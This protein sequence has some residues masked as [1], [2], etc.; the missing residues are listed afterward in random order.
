MAGVRSVSSSSDA[1]AARRAEEAKKAEEARKAQEAKR[2]EAAKKAE[3]AKKAQETQ[4]ARQQ[5]QADKVALK[6]EDNDIKKK[7]D[8]KAF[9]SLISNISKFASEDGEGP[10]AGKALGPVKPDGN[11][12]VDEDLSKLREFTKIYSAPPD[13]AG[14]SEKKTEAGAEQKAAKA[15]ESTEDKNKAAEENQEKEGA[16]PQNPLKETNKV[17]STVKTAYEKMDEMADKDPSQALQPDS[18]KAGMNKVDDKLGLTPEVKDAFKDGASKLKTANTLLSLPG[19]INNLAKSVE[20][21]DTEKIVENG[22]K[23]TKDGAVLAD[24]ALKAGGNA[25]ADAGKA[26]TKA[27]GTTADAGK[28]GVKALDT[29]ADAGKIGVKAGGEIAGKALGKAIPVVDTAVSAA[30]GYNDAI[31]SAEERGELTD[32]N[33]VAV[34]VGGA[35]GGVLGDKGGELAGAAIGFAIG[36]P[37]GAVVGL[38]AGAVIGYFASDA[39][40]DLGGKVGG[41]VSGLFS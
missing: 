23:V 36:G 2:A 31:Q 13:D 10:D 27:L 20:D 22:L 1:A 35:I 14:S 37:V 28:A 26:G 8:P 38:A 29:A 4:K 16:A 6:G 15:G 11:E 24:A 5:A 17:V 7:G 21:G 41:W 19:D 30:C 25:A 9:D 39:M 12:K 3:E 33:K 34:G 32:E 18:L 40:A